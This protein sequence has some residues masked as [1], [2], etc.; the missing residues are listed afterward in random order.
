MLALTLVNS[1]E[2]KVASVSSF[3][4]PSANSASAYG[5]TN[6]IRAPA[7]EL[8]LREVDLR[9]QELDAQERRVVWDADGLAD[10]GVMSNLDSIIENQGTPAIVPYAHL[11]VLRVKDDGT[12]SQVATITGSS[13]ETHDPPRTEALAKNDVEMPLLV[14]GKVNDLEMLVSV[15][16]HSLVFRCQP[17]LIY[18]QNAQLAAEAGQPVSQTQKLSFSKDVSVSPIPSTPVMGNHTTSTRTTKSL[19]HDT[20]KNQTQTTQDVDTQMLLDKMANTIGDGAH[21]YGT[22]TLRGI[23]LHRAYSYQVDSSK[24]LE[25]MDTQAAPSTQTSQLRKSAR[26]LAGEKAQEAMDNVDCECGI[27]VGASSSELDLS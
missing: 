22:Q 13:L 18:S 15:I 9:Q 27:S 25:L 5:S 10:A 14:S 24:L 3:I 16:W 2:L 20:S 8:A 26:K 7:E 23:I 6:N 21:V 12:L 1:V 19:P 17:Q 11:G 4:P